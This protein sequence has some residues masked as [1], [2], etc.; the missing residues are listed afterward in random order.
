[1][2][3]EASR[4]NTPPKTA[5]S[6]PTSA[7]GVAPDSFPLDWHRFVAIS[8]FCLMSAGNAIQ[9]ITF[10]NIV[11][12]SAEFF[13]CTE[14]QIN[15]LSTVYFIEYAVF[16]AFS[17]EMV[18][19][20][21]YKRSTLIGSV[22]NTIGAALKLI[23]ALWY[24]KY[25]LLML[26]QATTGMAQLVILSLP[27]LVS[28][29]W[30]GESVQTAVISIASMAGSLGVGLGMLLPPLFVDGKRSS[31][32]AFIYLFI[33]ELGVCAVDVLMNFFLVPPQP[34]FPPNL[35]EAQ[36]REAQRLA[37]EAQQG[38]SG[39]PQSALRVCI[40]HFL[41]TMRKAWEAMQSGAV[42]AI[43]VAQGLV[44]GLMWSCG[45]FLAQ[46]L[47]P[48]GISANVV[49]WMGFANI[50]S[51]VVA[52]NAASYALDKYHS[53]QWPLAVAYLVA[54]VT[55]AVM[56]LVCGVTSDHSV[57]QVVVFVAYVLVGAATNS[58]IPIAF[59]FAVELTYPMAEEISSGLIMFAGNF[60]GAIL[61]IVLTFTVGNGASQ[62]TSLWLMGSLAV[63]CFIAAVI[64]ALFTKAPLKR[65]ESTLRLV[66]VHSSGSPSNDCPVSVCPTSNSPN[67]LLPSHS[68]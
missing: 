61:M 60:L 31:A 10:A 13:D 4:S 42:C 25:W 35:A 38:E 47:D 56:P 15:W 5:T 52:A 59:E 21:G 14:M 11:P 50:V 62:S 20:V 32:S 26:G 53:F 49:G 66:A 18:S 37:S 22:L 45:S 46:L 17:S 41:E 34:E 68:S 64:T 44:L 63:I 28:T 67:I 23:G 1:M 57:V 55:V 33:F 12:D 48:F 7:I 54:A 27:P 51:G 58:C 39:P 3:V 6:D 8:E 65:H 43:V 36:K 40:S 2:T 29:A 16:I 30:F 19:R 9:W 24:R